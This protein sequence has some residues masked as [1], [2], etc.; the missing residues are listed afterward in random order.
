MT[1]R[2]ISPPKKVYVTLNLWNT[3]LST[4]NLMRNSLFDDGT[5]GFNTIVIFDRTKPEFE[6][7]QKNPI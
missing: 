2:E 5:N 3:A 1:I 7:S 4:Y 6:L